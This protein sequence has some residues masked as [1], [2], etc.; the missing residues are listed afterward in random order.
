MSGIIQQK[1][2]NQGAKL[3]GKIA[4][5]IYFVGNTTGTTAFGGG[6]TWVRIGAGDAMHPL[7]SL[8][9]I[10]PVSAPSATGTNDYFELTGA[11]TALQQLWYRYGKRA[12]H[13][14]TYSL[15]L[16]DTAAMAPATGVLISARVVGVDAN[17]VATPIAQSVRTFTCFVQSSPVSHT[18]PIVA[19]SAEAFYLE[20]NNIDTVSDD[21]NPI[22]REAFLS[23]YE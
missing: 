13:Y 10:Q 1:G 15:S 23:I 8:M 5:G 18:F 17:S 21:R 2:I 20:V 14:C 19:P 9:P 3:T 12:V 16:I 4:A 11:T 6:G 7:F 22:V